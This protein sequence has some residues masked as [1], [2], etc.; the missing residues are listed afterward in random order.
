[1]NEETLGNTLPHPSLSHPTLPYP[2]R[3][4]G[5]FVHIKD[6]TRAVLNHQQQQ[7]AWSPSAEDASAEERRS[8]STCSSL[9]GVRVQLQ[10]N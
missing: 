4:S 7:L 8:K 1:M 9:R 3:L 2:T 10:R 6:A 5:A